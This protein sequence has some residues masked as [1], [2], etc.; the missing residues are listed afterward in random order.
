MPRFIHLPIGAAV[1]ALASVPY[2]GRLP[3]APRNLGAQA[4]GL[5]RTGEWTIDPMHSTLSFAIDHAGI[6]KVY[7][8]FTQFSGSVTDDEKDPSKAKV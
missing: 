4:S 2:S 1:L 5:S 8:R 3:E 7:G 6:N